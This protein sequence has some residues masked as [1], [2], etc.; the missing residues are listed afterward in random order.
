MSSI[1]ASFSVVVGRDAV[2]KGQYAFAS[3]PEMFHKKAKFMN[4]LYVIDLETVTTRAWSDV[5]GTAT[6]CGSGAFTR[7]LVRME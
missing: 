5:S 3:V 1:L 4:G 2:T 6:G 7:L